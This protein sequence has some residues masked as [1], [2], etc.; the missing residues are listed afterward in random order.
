MADIVC[1]SGGFDPLCGGHIDYIEG[2]YRYGRVVVILNSDEWLVRKK[3]Y[4]FM[5]FD[6][7]KKILMAM[8]HVY[9]VAAVNDSDGSV[10]EALERINPKYF[11]NGGDRTMENTLEL[12]LCNVLKI[13]PLFG[14]GGGKTTSSSELVRAAC[15]QMN[16]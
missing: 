15:R 1:V 5:P 3:G 2:A 9:D 12:N 8:R 10:C 6:R 14:I 16:S 7:R 13:I 11:A 4:C